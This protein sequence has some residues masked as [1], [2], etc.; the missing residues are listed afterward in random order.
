MLDFSVQLRG[1]NQRLGRD[2]TAVEAGATQ[3]P[4]FND[5]DRRSQLRRADRGRVPAGAGA[6][7]YDVKRFHNS[8]SSSFCLIELI[9]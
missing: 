8:I 7:D 6:D 4:A 1:G 5:G 9:N 3:M 2:T